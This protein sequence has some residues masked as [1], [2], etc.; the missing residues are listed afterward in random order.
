MVT[1]TMMVTK[2]IQCDGRLAS[3][4]LIGIN[5]KKNCFCY[6]HYYNDLGSMLTDNVDDV[7]QPLKTVGH[8]TRK[9]YGKHTLNKNVGNQKTPAHPTINL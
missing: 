4:Y 1:I 3:V 6:N 7:E 2:P 8:H 9:V 5:T